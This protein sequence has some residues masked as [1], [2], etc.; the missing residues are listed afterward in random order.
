M[1]T[2]I[3]KNKLKIFGLS[4]LACI[5]LDALYLFVVWPDWE[6]FKSGVVR[7]SRYIEEYS[8][9]PRN[10]SKQAPLR[11]KPQSRLTIPQNIQ[12]VFILAEDSRFYSHSGI[13][14]AALVTVMKYRWLKGR[15]TAGGSTISQQTTKNLFLSFSRTPLRKWHEIVLTLSMEQQLKK[16]RILTIY[17][18]IVE[19]GRGLFGIEAASQYYFGI[20]AHSLTQ[21]E[22]AE[23]AATLPS[24][25]NHNP[26]RRT[27]AFLARK[28]RITKHLAAW[29]RFQQKQQDQKRKQQPTEEDQDKPTDQN[30]E[31]INEFS[32]DE[33]ISLKETEEMEAF[34]N[35]Y[36]DEPFYEP[37]TI[38]DE[39]EFIEEIDQ[40]ETESETNDSWPFLDN[41]ESESGSAEDNTSPSDNSY[42]DSPPSTVL[43]VTPVTPNTE[44][45]EWDT[46]E[47][48]PSENGDGD[49][50]SSDPASSAPPIE[51]LKPAIPRSE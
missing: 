22:A 16:T 40:S 46:T 7:K 10:T 41:E 31:K 48:Q 25:K 19:L 12:K 4:V 8:K 32:L 18:N 45:T 3:S 13:D 43:D 37:D 34:E 5:V 47:A 35:E 30:D 50:D 24:P 39:T 36:D 6:K 33:F 1:I 23:L 28:K 51:K 42:Q 11:W 38:D 9:K 15:F 17:L 27:K 44:E 49:T 2:Y 14:V 26:K 21:N 20:P 29:N